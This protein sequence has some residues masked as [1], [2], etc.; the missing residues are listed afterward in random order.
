MNEH[1]HEQRL[2]DSVTVNPAFAADP[3]IAHDLTL[4]LLDKPSE[5]GNALLKVSFPKGRIGSPYLAFMDEDRKIVLRDDGID[6]DEVKGDGIYTGIVQADLEALREMRRRQ[7][8]EKMEGPVQRIVYRGHSVAD[9]TRVFPTDL[10]TFF[11]GGAIHVHWPPFPLSM[12][13]TDSIRA[14]SVFVTDPA[15]VRDTTRTYDP[16][17]NKGHKMGP[18]TFGFLMTQLAN[19]STT[20]VSPSRFVLNWLLSYGHHTTEN[21]DLPGARPDMEAFIHNWLVNSNGLQDSTLDLSIAPFRLI[22]IVNCLDLR[23]NPGYPGSAGN[24]GEGKFVFTGVSANGSA[25]AFTVIFEYTISETTCSAI[26]AYAREWYDLKDLTIGSPAYNSAL[27]HIT[28]GF[29]LAGNK[30]QAE[31]AAAGDD[32]DSTNIKRMAQDLVDLVNSPCIFV[33]FYYEPLN[34]VQ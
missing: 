12:S 29:N 10:K 2:L 13:L 22:A 8:R 15:V 4:R 21:L 23:G 20:G 1:K 32:E 30:M 31:P 9:T 24:A 26:K 33:P 34:K 6:P 19:Q 25:Q 17:T 5:E 27:Q 11:E 28:D 7:I 16:G 18:W 14:S 3:P